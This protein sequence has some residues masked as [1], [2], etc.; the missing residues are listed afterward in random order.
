MTDA[1]TGTGVTVGDASNEVEQ[2]DR[3]VQVY[4]LPRYDTSTWFVL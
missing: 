3:D 2:R 1:L 4:A